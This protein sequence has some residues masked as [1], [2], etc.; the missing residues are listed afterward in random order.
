MKRFIYIFFTLIII[1]LLAKGA[2]NLPY[3]SSLICSLFLPVCFIFFFRRIDVFEPEPYKDLFFAFFLSV[4]SLTLLFIFVLPIWHSA[5]N[6][7]VG[8]MSFLKMFLGVAVME[9]FFKILPVLYI[10]KKTNWINEPIDYII[11][12]SI[13]ALGFAFIENL[14]YIYKHHQSGASIV[15]V[16]NIEP[17]FM[18]MCTT[19]FLSF[20]L[21]CYKI[22]SK[23]KYVVIGFLFATLFH[24]IYNQLCGV[25]AFFFTAEIIPLIIMV[26]IYAKLIHSL[27]NISPFYNKEKE[28]E[29]AGA[30]KLLFFMLSGIV[31]VSFFSEYYFDPN[32]K[33]ENTLPSTIYFFILAMILYWRISSYLKVERGRFIALDYQIGDIKLENQDIV[34]LRNEIS[35]FYDKEENQKNQI[36]NQSKRI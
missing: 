1:S 4:V 31:I 33:L 18:H 17:L 7:Y 15:A 29:V 8:N 23:N 12:A 19:S 28:S 2:Y 30:G 11:Y 16:R 21:F 3:L 25:K 14:D 9:E 10:L 35:C 34:N 27:M 5:F 6:V 26:T 22:T 32:F 20:G 13:S 24:T 36:E